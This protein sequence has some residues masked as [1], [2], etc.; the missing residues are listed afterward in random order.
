[1]TQQSAY[2]PAH[3]ELEA[4]LYA[5]IGQDPQGLPLTV[6][7]ALARIGADPR[8]EADRLRKLPRDAAMRAMTD[9]IEAL[10]E[11]SWTTADVRQLADG[12]LARL[13]N[14][15]D[16]LVSTAGSGASAQMGRLASKPV[17][18]MRMAIYAA[19]AALLLLFVW[20]LLQA[21]DDGVALGAIDGGSNPVAFLEAQT[22][23][24]LRG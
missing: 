20:N 23:S 11:G 22:N 2:G 21:P 6:Q 15:K 18:A 1:M 5:E 7:S 13:P 19:F 24:D 4:F 3:P 8:S 17:S 12:L 9:M 16:R 10:P 14:R